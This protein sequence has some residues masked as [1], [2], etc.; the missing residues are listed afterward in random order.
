VDEK[1]KKIS[2]KSLTFSFERGKL[3]KL[4]P[5]GGWIENFFKKVLDKSKLL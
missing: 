2:E 3:L 1:N 5:Q 4:S